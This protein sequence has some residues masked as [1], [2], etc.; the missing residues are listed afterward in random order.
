MGLTPDRAPGPSIEEE[1]QLEDQGPG[2]TPSVIGALVQADGVIL[3]RDATGVFDLRSGSGISEAQH[4]VLDTLVH[5]LA[6]TCYL[7][8]TRTA[9][10]VSNVTIWTDSGKTT[11]VREL[12]N[13]VRTAGRIVS[14]DLIQ[15]DGAGVVKQTV[16]YAITRTGGRVSSIQMTES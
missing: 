12:A 4:E 9:G 1:L 8:V 13:V 10:R 2:A 5:A 7:E 6:E 14:Y 11:K 16:S 3:G 15:Y